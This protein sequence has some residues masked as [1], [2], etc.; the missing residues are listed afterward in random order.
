MFVKHKTDMSDTISIAFF[1]MLNH[2]CF[3][4]SF[5]SE[6]CANVHLYMK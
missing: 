3:A 6:T 2:I 1:L 4:N 5:I